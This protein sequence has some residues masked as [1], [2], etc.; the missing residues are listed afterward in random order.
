MDLLEFIFIPSGCTRFLHFF[1]KEILLASQFTL[2]TIDTSRIGMNAYNKP[3]YFNNLELSIYYLLFPAS[4]NYTD[5]LVL[6]SVTH[7]NNNG[8]CIYS[9]LKK[10][11]F[12]S[13]PTLGPIALIIGTHL[14]QQS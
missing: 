1:F 3:E 14:T 12:L 5:S 13:M 11:I 9:L 8:F 4:Q 2:V 7:K 6:K 10:L